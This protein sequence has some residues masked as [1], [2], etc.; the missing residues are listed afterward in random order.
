MDQLL[1]QGPPGA[2]GPGHIAAEADAQLGAQL[3]ALQGFAVGGEVG[4]AVVITFPAALGGQGFAHIQQK[5]LLQLGWPVHHQINRCSAVGRFRPAPETHRQGGQGQW[6]DGR[7]SVIGAGT[8]QIPLGRAGTF[9]AEQRRLMGMQPL[10]PGEQLLPLQGQVGPV[11]E[12]QRTG[13]EQIPLHQG[14]GRLGPAR[15]LPKLT[16]P[17]RASTLLAGR[18]SRSCRSA[19]SLKPARRRSRIRLASRCSGQPSSAS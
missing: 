13:G 3:T 11:V 2:G 15:R 7:R 6:I 18:Q 12:G 16:R 19:R 17:I 4:L 14:S 10:L 9:A 5:R 8:E 1:F